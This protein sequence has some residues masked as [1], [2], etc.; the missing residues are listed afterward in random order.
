MTTRL[1][2]P[3]LEAAMPTGMVVQWKAGGSTEVG[4]VV[5][6][7][8]KDVLVLSTYAKTVAREK[9]TTTYR[10]AYMTSLLPPIKSGPLQRD[11]HRIPRA[12]LQKQGLVTGREKNMYKMIAAALRKNAS[13]KMKEE[14]LH[15]SGIGR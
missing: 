13:A 2:Q 11:V 5:G 9:S 10:D 12:R 3:L 4:I 14:L 15:L 6:T 1:A 7:S 8:G